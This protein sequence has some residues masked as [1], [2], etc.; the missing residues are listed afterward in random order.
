MCCVRH[1]EGLTFAIG[2]LLAFI[3]MALLFYFILRLRCRA[4]YMRNMNI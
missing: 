3:V 4:L 2:A 1:S